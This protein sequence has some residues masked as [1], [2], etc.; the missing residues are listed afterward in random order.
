MIFDPLSSLSLN[1]KLF[2]LG[3]LLS[4]NNL[5]FGWRFVVYIVIPVRLEPV[6]LVIKLL[7][8]KFFDAFDLSN[9]FTS[10]LIQLFNGFLFLISELILNFLGSLFDFLVEI[11]DFSCCL[12]NWMVTQQHGILCQ[13]VIELWNLNQTLKID[14]TTQSI[15]MRLN[16]STNGLCEGL[17]GI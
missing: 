10:L 4:H 1:F 11:L 7:R 9:R 8:D 12:D 2:L 5:V 14:A 13:H 15:K 6:D 17:Q 3:V 16:L